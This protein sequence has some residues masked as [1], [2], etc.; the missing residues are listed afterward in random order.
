MKSKHTQAYSTL[1]TMIIISSVLFIGTIVATEHDLAT[2]RLQNYSQDVH[3]STHAATSCAYSGR[4]MLFENPWRSTL[5]NETIAVGS[6]TC[7]FLTLS[8]NGSVLLLTVW[9]SAGKSTTTL[10]VE[11]EQVT[12]RLRTISE[13]THTLD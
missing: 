4:G 10:T 5:P 2:R 8:R 7:G 11:I 9:G 3:A 12:S 13:V 6:S 1:L